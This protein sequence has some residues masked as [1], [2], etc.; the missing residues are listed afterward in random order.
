PQRI[1]VG[2]FKSFLNHSTAMVFV[3]GPQ[4]PRMNAVELCISSKFQRARVEN[5]DA[6]FPLLGIHSPS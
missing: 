1:V 2:V 5:P 3:D 4:R 6:R